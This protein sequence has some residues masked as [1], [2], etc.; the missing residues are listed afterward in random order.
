MRKGPDCE[1]ETFF[2][3]GMMDEGEMGGRERR[4]VGRRWGGWRWRGWRTWN[5]REHLTEKQAM[6]SAGRGGE[7]EL[8]GGGEVCS[9]VEGRRGEGRL[10]LAH[11]HLFVVLDMNAKG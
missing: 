8:C 7:A 1:V 6:N 2:L 4:G 5:V 10:C 11:Q 3:F 9:C